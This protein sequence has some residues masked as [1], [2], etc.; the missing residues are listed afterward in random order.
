MDIKC[1]AVAIGLLGFFCTA[2]LCRGEDQEP[3]A[4]DQAAQRREAAE[5]RIEQ[6]LD[7]PLRSP[8]RFEGVELS[9]VFDAIAEEYDIPMVL[10]VAKLEALPVGP[11][12]HVTIDLQNVSL[13]SAINLI[14]QQLGDVTFIVHDE[15]LQITSTY[16]AEQDLVTR[17]YRVDMFNSWWE[18]E[19]PKELEGA[20][21]ADFNPLIDVIT[22]SIAQ[23]TWV[24]NGTGV[25]TIYTIPPGI[26]VIS[27]TKLV[28]AK[29]ERLLDDLRRVTEEI[30]S[31][32]KKWKTAPTS[33]ETLTTSAAGR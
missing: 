31:D 22:T 20:A 21:H 2:S 30:Q 1:R 10:D 14:L 32:K 17:V 8:L 6:T 26:L 11:E 5:Q 12:S 33:N 27:Q 13:R 7:E 28:H 24:E 3:A 16:R 9:A 15:V 18:K 4:N 19:D 23:D 25:A 29:V